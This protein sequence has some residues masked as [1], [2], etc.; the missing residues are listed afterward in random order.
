MSALKKLKGRSVARMVFVLLW[1]ALLALYIA[2][3]IDF[4]THYGAANY[5]QQHNKYWVAMLGLGIVIWVVERR[6]PQD[7]S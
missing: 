3:K 6:F 2:S 5:V 7:N 4:F 1:S